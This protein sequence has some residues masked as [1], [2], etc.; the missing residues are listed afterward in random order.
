MSIIFD[1]LAEHERALRD[2]RY[3][4]VELTQAY[5]AHIEKTDAAIG[6]YLTVLKDRALHD[7]ANADRARAAGDTRPLLGVPI[8]L[9]DIFLTKGVRTT[10]SSRFLESYVPPITGTAAQKLEDAGC[11]L[12]G[13][14][15]MDEFAMGSSTENS[16]LQKTRNPWDLTCAPGGSSGGSASAV[17]AHQ[18]AA[19]LGTDTGGSIRQP[20]AFC[21]VTGLKPTYGRVS[22]YGVIAFA[23]S[24][25]Q[26]GPLTKTV[27]DAAIML[28][29][30]AGHDP[31]DMTSSPIA[32]PNYREALTKNTKDLV[33]GIPKEY[34]LDGLDPD[35][36]AAVDQAMRTY[37]A[38]GVRF[39]DVSL[40]HTE[41]AVATY[42]IIAPAEASSNLARFDGIRYGARDTS[43]KTLIE[44]Y[45]RSR[46]AGFGP[47]VTRRI[48]LGTYVLSA[49]YYDAYYLKAQKVRT[50]IKQDFDRAFEKVD[51]LLTPVTPTP[52]FRIGE[53]VSDPLQMYL[54]DVFTIPIN[55]AGLPGLSVPAGFTKTG[56]PLAFQLIGK[57]FDESTLLQL[58]HAYQNATTW[59]RERPK[60]I[61]S[62]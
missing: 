42:Y 45:E 11:I 29:A 14:L 49:G 26:V 2:K 31:R 9:K 52:P 58:G 16:A 46:T 60:T 3:T 17:A 13:K 38:L 20:A 33:I 39:E 43:G 59:H 25:D 6:S 28:E 15:N 47:E 23:S 57:P 50:L 10:C 36:Q 48:M 41:Y 37:E 62:A 8:A 4:S 61:V 40:P 22:R 12:L 5:L 24:L 18:C 30:I 34:R 1:T 7:A 53:K 27:E 51:A 44:T 35:I 21:G 19:S 32:V 54:S 56:L 55:M